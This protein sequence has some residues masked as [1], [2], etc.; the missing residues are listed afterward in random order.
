M[1]FPFSGCPHASLGDG[2]T[3]LEPSLIEVFAEVMEGFGDDP[4]GL[5]L[6]WMFWIFDDVYPSIGIVECG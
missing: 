4:F 2:F 6:V 3:I 5:F 1:S